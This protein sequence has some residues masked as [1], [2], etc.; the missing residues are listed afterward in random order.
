MSATAAA[1]TTWAWSSSPVPTPNEVALTRAWAVVVAVTLVVH[2]YVQ[3]SV[4]S[5]ELSALLSPPVGTTGPHLSSVSFTAVSGTLPLFR[6]TYVNVTVPP[7][8]GN[9]TGDADSTTEM[10]GLPRLTLSC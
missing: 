10:F 6:T 9:T 4:R 1:T 2:E 5:G 8:A 3:V 7:H